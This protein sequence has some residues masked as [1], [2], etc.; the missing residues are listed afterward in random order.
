MMVTGNWTQEILE[1]YIQDQV[2]ESLTLEYK[3]GEAL[4]LGSQRYKEIAK[5][6]SAMANSAGGL[7][8][9]GIREGDT[10]E[11]RHW[12]TEFRPVNRQECTK[13]TLEQIISS[14]IQPRL[15]NVKIYPVALNSDP[16][17]VVYIVKIPQSDTVHQVIRNK[18]YY[19]R[20]NFESVPMEDYEIRDVLNRISHPEVESR[21]G[22]MS[23]LETAAGNRWA[24][25]IF[26]KNKSLTVAKD[27]AI[28]VEFYDLQPIHNVQAERFRTKTRPKPNQNDMYIATFSEA[29]HRGM[30]KYFGTFYVTIPEPQ[31]FS[32]RVQVFADGMRAKW[33]RIK[34]NFG[35]TSATIQ[36]QD[37]GYLY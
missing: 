37:E 36:M 4:G 32:F 25:P 20:F 9:Y 8:I 34:L 11:T 28:T 33:W 10:R 23:Y 15:S 18:R 6:V 1:A 27:T 26:A 24:I 30:W 2:E 12:P 5:D 14:N 19:K 29:V 16:N 22:H 17:H 35:E 31:S 13:E 3:S 7:I 21:I